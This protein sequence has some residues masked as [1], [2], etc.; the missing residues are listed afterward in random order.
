MNQENTL[1]TPWTED[2]LP[3]EPIPSKY[4]PYAGFW[5]RALAFLIDVFLS[6]IVPA[7]VCFPIMIFLATESFAAEQMGEDVSVYSIAML[8]TYLLWNV[9]GALSFWLYFSLQEGGKHQA[10]WGKRLLKIKVVSKEGSPLSFAHATGRTVA[11]IISY[12]TFYLGFLMMPFSNRK[13]ALHDYIAETY[14]VKATY[15]QEDSFPDTPSHW[16]TFLTIVIVC[17]LLAA[18]LLLQ[19]AKNTANST[20]LKA[21]IALSVLPAMAQQEDAPETFT[22]NDISFLQDE[23]GYRAIF[24]DDKGESYVLY[25][26]EPNGTVCCDIFPNEDC[27]NISVPVCQ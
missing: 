16:G 15:K 25:L 17:A 1:K 2:V 14:V 21:K 23:T 10:T 9:L 13:R 6:A 24:L 26:P 4:A 18:T 22:Q 20:A 11:K 12:L 3:Q 19:V 8:V 5:S 7:L 27:Q